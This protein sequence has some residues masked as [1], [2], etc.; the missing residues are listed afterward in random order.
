MLD[1]QYGRNHF[2]VVMNVFMAILFQNTVAGWEQPRCGRKI[3]RFSNRE[4]Q[5]KGFTY[6]LIV[7][8]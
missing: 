3:W 5:V 2:L 6:T 1:L 7:I 4:K 8:N